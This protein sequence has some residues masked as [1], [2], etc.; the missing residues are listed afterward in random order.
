MKRNNGIRRIV[1]GIACILVLMAV[2][3]I[4]VTAGGGSGR[5]ESPQPDSAVHHQERNDGISFE[6]D[7]ELR[8]R[9]VR[10]MTR[11][12]A[13]APNPVEPQDAYLQKLYDGTILCFAEAAREVWP[14]LD[15]GFLS[16]TMLFE[17]DKE[18]AEFMELARRLIGSVRIDKPEDITY[19]VNKDTLAELLRQDGR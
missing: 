7:D 1:V 13:E 18:K 8:G 10:V 2:I 6:K 12:A 11:R 17:D 5:Q 14:E 9:M 4:C 16:D 3:W 15:S 19:W